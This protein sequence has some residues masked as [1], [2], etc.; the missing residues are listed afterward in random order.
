MSTKTQELIFQKRKFINRTLPL[1]FFT[2]IMVLVSVSFCGVFLYNQSQIMQHEKISQGMQAR[3]SS[4]AEN[5][6]KKSEE[7]TKIEKDNIYNAVHEYGMIAKRK[8]TR[9]DIYIPVCK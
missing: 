2:F 4:C 6:L 7:L 1:S 8:A 5:R 9:Y 3:I